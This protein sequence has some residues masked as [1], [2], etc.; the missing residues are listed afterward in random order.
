MHMTVIRSGHRPSSIMTAPNACSQFGKHDTEIH[1]CAPAM[2]TSY[3]VHL[4]SMHTRYCKPLQNKCQWIAW[5]CIASQ[6]LMPAE[7]SHLASDASM[8]A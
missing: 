4:A 5:A 8:P 3:I 7:S 2:G 6:G 1:T